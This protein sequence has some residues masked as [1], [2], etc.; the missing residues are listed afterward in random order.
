MALVRRRPPAR[1]RT[2]AKPEP[3]E[4]L[5]V[6]R[7]AVDMSLP[8]LDRPFDYLV[9]ADA[10]C[11]PGCRVRVRF[12]GS[13]VDGFVLDRVDRSEHEGRLAFL[14]RVVSGEPVLA[15][16]VATLARAVADR[17][18]GTMADVLRLAVPPR[19]AKVE[20][21]P[22]GVAAPAPQPP[23]GPGP[24][25]EYT[26]GAAY[27][28]ELAA[29]RPA[30]AVWN[31]LPGADWPAAIAHAVATVRSVGNGAVVVVPDHRDVARLDA[32]VRAACGPDQHVV[33]TAELGPAQRY[34]RWLAVR[35]GAVQVVVGTRAAMFAP[36][37]D[38]GL[39]VCWDDGDDLHAEQRAPYPHVREVLCLRAHR[40]GAAALIGG[41]AST[42]EGA[43]LLA[44][45]WAHAVAGD[46][47]AVRAAMP[48]VRVAGDDADLAR[49]PA[50]R[51][52]RLPQSAWRAAKE[53]LA[54]GPVL[55]QTPRRGYVPVLACR[56]C[57]H[58]AHCPHCQGPLAATGDGQPACRLC[59][60]PVANWR[61]PSCSA[62]GLRAV[63]VGAARTAEELGKAFPGVR[64]R[65][66]GGD[67]DVLAEVP[68]AGQLVVATP[69]AEPVAAGGY[70]AALLLD[71]WALLGRADLRAA[72]EALRRWL[73][74][75]ALVR[76]GS[77]G[78]RV[79]VLADSSLPVVQALVRWDP[80]G[81]AERELADRAELRF[82]PAVR[83]AAV[84]GDATAVDELLGAD[85][86]PEV[87]DVLG[88]VPLPGDPQEVRAL[89]RV[90]RRDGAA[91]AAGL[92]A[93]LAVRSAVKAPGK[94]RVQV[95]PLE[96]L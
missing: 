56:S 83:A 78:G 44:T 92:H 42:A 68:A 16:Q 51:S 35:R 30:R 53:A 89:V 2:A 49:D 82:P 4:R 33:L 91:L 32:A 94:V 84:T 22:P 37:H 31:A 66:S 26:A 80:A 88:P 76:T 3:A 55:V 73:T 10:D 72:E 61:C 14:D 74:A 58:T 86:L 81:F 12:A 75:A 13:L 62:T 47:S 1:S 5:P 59:G 7:V 24:W 34:R 48:A 18:A 45:G 38:L 69:G 85:R 20:A 60:R 79:V 95:D 9:P 8:H 23:D 87:S 96:V 52:A 57:R 19:H 43:R 21:E 41:F 29:G 40:E 90:P 93:G 6:A 39:V 50:A 15:P 70:A 46:R 27:V 36:V 77:A 17:Y 65:V 67:A 25:A 54:H 71:G 11:V 63:V 64:V 28:R